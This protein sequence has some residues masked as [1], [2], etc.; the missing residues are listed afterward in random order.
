MP[1]KAALNRHIHAPGNAIRGAYWASNFETP[2]LGDIKHV[3]SECGDVMFF[4]GMRK[5]PF[6]SNRDSVEHLGYMASSLIDSRVHNLDGRLRNIEALRAQHENNPDK[7]MLPSIRKAS[8]SLSYD[9]QNET[10]WLMAEMGVSG[11]GL[12][13]S[14][15]SGHPE[16][17]KLLVE[18]SKLLPSQWM[19]STSGRSKLVKL[20]TEG[21]SAFYRN[22]L[23]Q[24]ERLRIVY[25][26]D[27]EL[28]YPDIES[29]EFAK[30]NDPIR[31]HTKHEILHE[32]THM[33]ERQSSSIKNLTG[34]FLLE[35]ST[36]DDG[37]ISVVT[38]GVKKD[39]KL[40]EDSFPNALCGRIY[41]DDY[42]ENEILARGVE[43]VIG[44]SNGSFIGLPEFHNGVMEERTP[45]PEYRSL[46]LGILL[47]MRIDD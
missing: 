44:G 45:D 13:A 33:S 34:A 43:S 27:G 21:N 41:D 38:Y 30:S 35:R 29:A 20:K 18:Y 36:R 1:S 15:I 28:A 23:Q 37:R 3:I 16:V 31:F 40:W 24:K 9:L 46:T 5:G 8:L 19:N 25:G 47:G 4:T 14:R 32:L 11:K 17:S 12:D 10:Q 42:K 39:K 26:A 22:P 6:K 7:D 2:S